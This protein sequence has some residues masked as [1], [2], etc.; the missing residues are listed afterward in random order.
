[1]RYFYGKLCLVLLEEHFGSIIQCIGNSLLYGTKTL[2]AIH[3]DTRLSLAEIKKG[4]SVLIK[5]GFVTYQRD[6]G[7]EYTLDH[8]KIIMILRYPRYMFFVKTEY[9]DEAEIM[10]EVVLK[11]GYIAA[12]KTIIETYKRLEHLSSNS[13]QKPSIPDLKDIFHLLITSKI[14][15]RS[16]FFDTTA[17]SAEKPD[18]N[19]PEI[20]V[21]AIHSILQG[22]GADLKDSKI[23]WKVNFDRLTE[24][25]RDQIIISA[26]KQRFDK[27]AG[28]LMTQ[29]INLMHSRT[30]SW[31]D[32][33]N[34]I[35]YTEIKE[36]VKMLNFPELEQ[37]LD[38]YLRLI[39]DDSSQFIKRVGDSGGGQYVVDMK[40]AFTKLA[41]VTLESI[42]TERFGSKASRIFRLVRD[43]KDVNLEQIQRLAMISIK[44]VKFLTY[45]L[46]QEN[47]IQMQ[48]IRKSGSLT[49]PSKEPFRFH[50]E[51]AKIVEMEIEHCCQA[52]YNIIKRRD[53]ETTSNKRMIEKELRVQILSFNMKE[54]GATEQQ[55]AELAEMM[56][57]SE[58]Q[59]L[60]KA[61]N[62]IK[63]LGATELQIDETLFLLTMYFRYH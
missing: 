41:W 37:Y 35:P 61:Q 20:D 36:K 62:A 51:L 50:I 59:Q 13:T 12:S 5:F 3:H 16:I 60:E 15:M 31:Q 38:Q 45:I 47:Y 40:N 42:V 2:T 8:N 24:N 53:H 63:K 32:T 49:T 30:V 33:S 25:L 56:T 14:L 22:Q 26:M 7:I 19:L 52:L 43:E 4:I 10:L 18:Y 44:D 17:E 11:N 21:T 28:K 46:T 58:T 29:L 54:H 57:P 39:E 27:N 48:E 1:M 6:N 34:P 23:Y 9:G 55:L